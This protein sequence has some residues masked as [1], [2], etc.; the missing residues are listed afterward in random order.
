MTVKGPVWLVGAGGMAV[1][2][3]RVLRALDITPVV[4]GRG[5]G[6]AAAFTAKTG[7][8]VHEGGLSAFLSRRPEPPVA[9]I[10][11]V[12][13]TQLAVTARRLLDYAQPRILL[14]KPGFLSQGEAQTVADA[15]R[16]ADV[17]VAYNRRFYE[18]V[19]A[20]R[21]M[22]DADGG[23]LSCLFEFTEWSHRIDPIVDRKDPREM[24]HWVLANSSHVIDLAFHLAGNPSRMQ[25]F[26][27]GSLS[28]HPSASAFAGAGVTDRGA[29]FSYHANWTAP[30]RWRV[31]VMSRLR[32]YLLCPMETLQIQEKG[33]VTWVPHELSDRRERE[34]KPGVFRM[35][36]AFLA[37][38]DP[39]M[40]GL[41]E[42]ARH[43]AM[44]DVIAG[45][46]SGAAEGA[47][48]T[49]DVPHS[50]GRAA[51]DGSSVPGPLKVG[52]DLP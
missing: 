7:V 38:H 31:E 49:W 11:A 15:V 17:A 26:R 23:P 51:H 28:W 36:E 46:S 6:T 45:Y 41:T 5:P 33:S 3:F 16:E 39:R 29:T 12:N 22:L 52:V 35:V 25:C 27:T 9:A 47:D 8:H 37:G 18:A 34:F 10:I 4:V 13:V 2:Y 20:L 32:R 44:Y 50:G 48:G 43:V 42:Q 21:A 30:G 1:E 19:T 40:C 14:E 24:S